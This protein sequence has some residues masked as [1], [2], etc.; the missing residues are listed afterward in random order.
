MAPL[1]VKGVVRS[2]RSRIHG[3]LRH[4]L[5][6]GR[7]RYSNVSPDA[8]EPDPTLGDEPPWKAFRGPEDRGY[9]VNA[10]QFFHGRLPC[11]TPG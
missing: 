5:F 7:D 2:C 11:L 4:E 3:S 9:F 8:Y 10:Q 6:Q 1:Y